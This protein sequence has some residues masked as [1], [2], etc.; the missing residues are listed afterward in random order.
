MYVDSIFYRLSSLIKTSPLLLSWTI[1]EGGAGFSQTAESQ[2][3]LLSAYL[4][5][6]TVFKKRF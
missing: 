6:R 1:G 5:L 4:K 2:M 3:G